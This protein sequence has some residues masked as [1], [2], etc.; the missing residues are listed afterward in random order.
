MHPYEMQRLIRQ[1]HKDE[2]LDLRPGSLYHA[3][4]RLQRAA[5][6]EPVET[7]REGKRPERTVYRLTELGEREVLD[8]LRELLARPV[9]EKSQF[10]AAMSHI[11]HLT[12]EDARDQLIER[13]NRLEV[14]V[15]AL[16]AVLQSLTARLP[17][18]V[19]VEAEYA[20]AM[21]QAEREWVLTLLE[22]LRS[23][24]LTW[25]HETLCRFQEMPSVERPPPEVSGPA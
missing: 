24:R 17:R 1:R 2:F 11:A 4:E 16:D 8:W 7:S 6:I 19:L 5:L 18:V 20:R 23:G 12:P 22:D 10:L 3:I 25:S 14:A 15:V 21:L 9:R 13:V